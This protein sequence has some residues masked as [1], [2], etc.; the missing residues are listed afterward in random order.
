[1]LKILQARLQQCMNDELP[2]RDQIANIRWIMEGGP[3]QRPCWSHWKVL[4]ARAGCAV[5][6]DAEVL[7]VDLDVDL[8]LD[9]GE[10]VDGGERGVAA[11][12]GVE[13]GDA[14]E[15]VNAALGAHVAVHEFAGHFQHGALDAGFVAGLSC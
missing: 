14:D 15:A 5:G 9:L 2:T 1:M 4:A 10:S 3:R 8:V 13:R 7:L 11:R 12:V 6:I